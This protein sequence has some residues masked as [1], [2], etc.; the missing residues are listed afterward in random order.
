MSRLTE[1]LENHENLNDLMSLLKHHAVNAE[2]IS[3]SLID[4]CNKQNDE[5]DQ[6]YSLDLIDDLHQFSARF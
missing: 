1:M 3:K 5:D 6:Q 4:Q 2:F